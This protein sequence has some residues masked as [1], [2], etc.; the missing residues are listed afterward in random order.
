MMMQK[1]Q[2]LISL[3]PDEIGSIILLEF[4]LGTKFNITSVM[5]QFSD[6]KGLFISLAIADVNV[7]MMNFIGI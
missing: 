3:E 2:K 5:I 4:P 1:I 7:Q 6:L